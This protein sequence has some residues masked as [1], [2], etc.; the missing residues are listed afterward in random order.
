MPTIS[1]LFVHPVK[2]LDSHRV[3]SARLRES[4]ALDGDRQYA[5]VDEDR[6]Y[7]NGKRERAVH[8]IESSFDPEARALTVSAPDRDAA[9]F[10]LD[11]ERG[12]LNAWLSEYFG[13]PVS[14][15][16]DPGGMP[17]D[18]DASGPTVISRET[19][20]AVAGWFDGIDATE[21]RRR[22]RPNII[23]EAGEPFWEDQL[24]ADRDSVVPFRLGDAELAGVNPCQRCVVPT[25]DP[26]TG[27]ET[28]GFRERFVERREATLPEWVDRDW[29]DHYFRLMVC[30]RLGEDAAGS[31]LRVGDEV[32]VIE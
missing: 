16:R 14:V 23:I 28:E 8:R 9:T 20:D 31:T 2:S 19:L 5:I 30:T 10:S 26:D 29:Y 6:E 22:L 27:A 3:D 18:T 7:V 11:A 25:R 17:D 32:T 12:S 24:Y 1:D 13:Y 21:M 4:G 15:I